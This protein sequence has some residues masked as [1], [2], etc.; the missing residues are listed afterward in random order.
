MFTK[1]AEVCKVLSRKRAECGPQKLLYTLQAR[2]PVACLLMLAATFTVFLDCLP[3]VNP[4]LT[5]LPR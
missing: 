4:V 2:K 3:T 5:S 1:R